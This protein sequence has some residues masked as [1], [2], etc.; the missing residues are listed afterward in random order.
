LIRTRATRRLLSG[1]RDT[2]A[3]ST[4]A[5]PLEVVLQNEHPF[6]PGAEPERVHD[7]AVGLAEAGATTLNVRFGHHSLDHYV[8][9]LAAMRELTP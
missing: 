2:E 8:E 1:S 9:Q 6:D 3:W 4:R 7:A 5:A